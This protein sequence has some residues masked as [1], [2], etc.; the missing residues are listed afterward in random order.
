MMAVRQTVTLEIK[1]IRIK[2]AENFDVQ[3]KEQE[4]Q[5][6]KERQEQELEEVRKSML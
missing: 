3:K 2:D 1:K 6:K 4:E 5:E